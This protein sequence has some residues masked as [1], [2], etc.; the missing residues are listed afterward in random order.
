LQSQSASEKLK[1]TFQTLRHSESELGI[2]GEI[3]VPGAVIRC[4]QLIPRQAHHRQE[5]TDL[6]QQGPAVSIGCSL[7]LTIKIEPAERCP[8]RQLEIPFDQRTTFLKVAS[9]E[10]S[11]DGSILP[12]SP[13]IHD[14][15][16][17]G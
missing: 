8:S 6:M 16:F 1:G 2:H 5:T 11:L 15:I 9:Q 17:A 14:H 10:K 12:F 13:L 4:G 3:V 7:S